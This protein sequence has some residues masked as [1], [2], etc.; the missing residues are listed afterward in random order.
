[1]GLELFVSISGG[2]GAGQISK[3]VEGFECSIFESNCR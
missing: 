2:T 3:T 1:M